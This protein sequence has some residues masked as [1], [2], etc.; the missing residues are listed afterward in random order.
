MQLIVKRDQAEKKGMFGGSKGMAFSLF[1][2][3]HITAEEKALIDKYQV[4]RYPLTKKTIPPSF[5][6]NEARVVT[7][8]IVDLLRGF[9]HETRDLSEL[10]QMEDQVKEGCVNLKNL[11]A[12]MASFGGERTFD[13][14]ELGATLESQP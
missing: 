8:E 3:C 4:E 2:Q 7:I 13:I 1:G 11:L 14:D 10:L 6:N 5:F 9:T 12:V